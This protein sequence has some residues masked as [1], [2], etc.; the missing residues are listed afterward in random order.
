MIRRRLVEGV[1]FAGVLF[2]MACLGGCPNSNGR[3]NA[4]VPGPNSAPEAIRLGALLPLT[5]DAAQWGMEPKKAIDLALEQVNARGG[6]QGRKIEVIYEDDK[7][8]A[9]MGTAGMQKLANVDK[10]PAVIGSVTSAVTLAVAPIAESA[11]VVLISPASTSHKVTD[12]GDYVF[13][14]IPSDVYEGGVMAERAYKQLGFRR[15]GVIHVDQAGPAG[16]AA[17]FTTRFKE[18]GG[19]IAASEKGAASS[20]DWRSQLTK[21]AGT[22]PQA[23]YAVTY[24]LEGGN[25]VKQ[26]RELGIATPILG[27]QPMEDPE[28]R[29]I[30]GTAADGVMFT[31]T[32]LSTEITGEPGRRFVAAFKAKYGKEPGSFAAEAYDAFDLVVDAMKKGKVDGP[33]IKSY[34]YTVRNY[35]GASGQMSFDKNGD[36]AKPIALMAIRGGKVVSAEKK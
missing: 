33:G 36:V 34:L 12:A 20:T 5:G 11:H 2:G 7:A 19:A 27:G 14:T 31:T 30:A 9:R 23:I 24:P 29:R 3:G 21:V 22:H 26:A 32:T 13:R 25:V 1:L 17:S 4:P 18:L 16:M 35:P 6:I 8:D 28:V 15:V 10:V